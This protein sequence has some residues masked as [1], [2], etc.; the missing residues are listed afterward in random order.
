MVPTWRRHRLCQGALTESDRLPCDEKNVGAK[1]HVAHSEDL[2]ALEHVDDGRVGGRRLVGERAA[3]VPEQ[4]AE[5]TLLGQIAM[6]LTIV[7]L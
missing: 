3:L 1:E 6:K 5:D 2:E 7:I 4:L